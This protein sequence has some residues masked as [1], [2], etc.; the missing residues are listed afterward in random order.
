MYIMYMYIYIMENNI[1]RIHF[2][3][4]LHSSEYWQLNMISQILSSHVRQ[5]ILWDLI[6]V[7]LLLAVPP[8]NMI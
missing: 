3:L 5:C 6:L 8:T 4:I 7:K 1:R 2:S